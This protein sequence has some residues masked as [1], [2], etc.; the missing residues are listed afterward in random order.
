LD[1]PESVWPT[2]PSLVSPSAG[3]LGRRTRKS[4]ESQHRY[5]YQHEVA[6]YDRRQLRGVDFVR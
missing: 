6:C 2:N 4:V 5:K 3:A 1:L